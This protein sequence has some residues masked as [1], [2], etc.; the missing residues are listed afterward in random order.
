MGLK[1]AVTVLSASSVTEIGFV[2]P[3][4]SPDQPSNTNPASGT[5][6]SSITVP[7]S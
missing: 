5:A 4:A 7:L 2:V 3:E 1:V 6:V